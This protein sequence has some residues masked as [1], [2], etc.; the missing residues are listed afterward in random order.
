LKFTLSVSF[1]IIPGLVQENVRPASFHRISVGRLPVP[2][3]YQK[4]VSAALH[5]RETAG[6]SIFGAR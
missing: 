3:Q 5:S 1:E 6:S 4:T 2:E